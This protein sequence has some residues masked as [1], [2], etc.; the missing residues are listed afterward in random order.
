MGGGREEWHGVWCS[1]MHLHLI[2]SSRKKGGRDCLYECDSVI[3]R[4]W[5]RI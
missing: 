2:V 1:E 4:L 5:M 3:I